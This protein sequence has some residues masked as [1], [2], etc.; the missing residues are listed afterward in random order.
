MVIEE[1][2][3]RGLCRDRF[4]RLQAKPRFGMN[5]ERTND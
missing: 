3:L 2:S 1:E 4:A 5:K